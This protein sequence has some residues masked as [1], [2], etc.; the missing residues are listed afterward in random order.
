MLE[1]NFNAVAL[2]RTPT[3]LENLIGYYLVM[4]GAFFY[5]GFVGIGRSSG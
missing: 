4:E 5:T 1:L 3:F 2:A